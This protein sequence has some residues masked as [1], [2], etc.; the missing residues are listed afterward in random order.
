MLIDD[1]LT[2][3]H[4]IDCVS[5]TIARNIGVMNK[6]KH[7]VPIR[8]LHTLYCTLIL[9]YLN[10]GVLIWGN[11]CKSYLDKLVKLQKW[12]IRTVSCSHYR[13]HTGPIFA[14]FNM[15]TVTDMYTLELGTFMY[16]YT[17][18]E[19][20]SSFKDY[21]KKRSDI[22]NYSTRH[23]NNFNLTKNKRIFSDH[24]VRTSGPHLWNSLENSYKISNSVKHFRNKFK[25]KL[26]SSYD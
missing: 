8:I 5:K 9:P 23:S 19:L 6:L 13:S 24:S 16:K 25:Q 1:C 10:Y 4:H 15:L 7:F 14:K 26:I 22:H 2:W 21:F 18:N 17:V 11:T 12:A 3:K 20:P